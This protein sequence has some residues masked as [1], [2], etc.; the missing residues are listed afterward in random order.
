MTAQPGNGTVPA[1]SLTTVQGTIQLENST[2][3]AWGAMKSAAAVAGVGLGIAVPAGGYRSLAMQQ[4]MI[5]NP[6][7]YN[8]KHGVA[9]ASAGNSTHG[10]GTCVDISPD[11]ANN[12]AAALNSSGNPNAHKFGFVRDRYPAYS[13]ENNHWHYIG[14]L[15][16]TGGNEMPSGNMLVN[17]DSISLMQLTE[18]QQASGAAWQTL[19]YLTGSSVASNIAET[20]LAGATYYQLIS[21]FNLTN[22]PVGEFVSVRLANWGIS[23]NAIV[24]YS[25]AMIVGTNSGTVRGQYSMQAHIAQSA[26]RLILQAY[27]SAPG[28]VLSGLTTRYFSW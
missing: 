10:F 19:P 7:D 13:Y 28:V 16:T 3:I 17:T 11:S 27:A 6:G 1:A 9:L 25:S 22:L 15:T 26:D 18:T 20:S 4:D 21:D 2:A 23:T 8:V 12:W 14:P 5:A 24:G